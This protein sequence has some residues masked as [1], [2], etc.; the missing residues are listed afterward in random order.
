MNKEWINK[1]F[2]Y[3]DILVYKISEDIV[4]WFILYCN[5]IKTSTAYCAGLHVL[6]ENRRKGIAEMLLKG[7]IDICRTR[8]FQKLT[9]YC[10]NPIAK[11]LYKKFG[12][13]EISCEPQ[14][15]YD[16]EVYSFMVLYL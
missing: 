5:D 3:A 1:I 13:I 10:N 8:R 6:P 4:G 11:E 2:R 12:F 16:G 14:E 15:Q 7:A 9:L